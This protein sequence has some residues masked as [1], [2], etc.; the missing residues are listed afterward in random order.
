MG[1]P[2]Q[3]TKETITVNGVNVTQLTETIDAIQKNPDLA[4]CELRADNRWLDGA[5]N[6]TTIQ[7]FYAAGQEDH[8][9]TKPFV[10]DAD[11]PPVLLG[12]NRGA[13]PVEYVLK[14]L[15]ACLTTSMVYHAAARGIKLERVESHLEGDLDLQGFLGLSQDIRKGYQNIRVNFKVKGDATPEQ[16]E[17]LAKFSPVRDI[18][19]NPVPVTVKVEME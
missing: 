7:G 19:S 3:K 2:A 15:A 10:F 4:Q 5:H 6:R 17:E 11:E 18:I 1:N 13:S 14:A 16:L 12:E 8:S 9:R